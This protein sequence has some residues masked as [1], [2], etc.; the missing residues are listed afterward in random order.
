MASGVQATIQIEGLE[1][2]LPREIELVF[3]RVGQ[4]SL[5]NIA[6]HAQAQHVGVSLRRENGSLSLEVMDDG[7]GFDP[8]AAPRRGPRGLGLL[9]MRERLAMIE[10]TLPKS[11]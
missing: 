8:A 11:S 2:R 1:R 6:R 9:G 7:I 4:E 10:D 5:S 3:Y